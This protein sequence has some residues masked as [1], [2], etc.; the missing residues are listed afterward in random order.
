[1]RNRIEQGQYGYIDFRKK[2]QLIKTIIGFSIV[3]IIFFTGILIYDTKATIVSVVAVLMALPASKSAVGY[4]SLFGKHTPNYDYFIALEQVLGEQSYLSDLIVSS[5]D[6]LMN[7]DFLI[8]R[9][10]KIHIFASNPKLDISSTEAYMNR[11]IKQEHKLSSLKIYSDFETF[12][13][14]VK[15]SLQHEAGENT[16]IKDNKIMK[17]ILTYSM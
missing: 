8:V 4:I 1:M 7:L 5:K 16:L 6:K 14:K 13:Y 11:I 9:D 12:L 15:S 3:F 2:V 10:G 17:L